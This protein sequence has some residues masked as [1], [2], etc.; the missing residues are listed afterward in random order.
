MLLCSD[1]PAG[2]SKETAGISEADV[3]TGVL[4]G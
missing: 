2:I 3:T 1:F 4:G